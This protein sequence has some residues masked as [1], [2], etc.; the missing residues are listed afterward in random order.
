MLFNIIYSV[1]QFILRVFFR[2]FFSP[3]I[4]GREN[5][6]KTGGFIVSC[7]HKSNFDPALIGAYLPKKIS[8]LAKRELFSNKLFGWFLKGLGAI[9]ITRQIAEIGTLKK[10]IKLLK[11][12]GII[13]IF[14]EGTR[15]NKKNI[16]NVKSGAVLF[17]IKGQVPIQPAVIVGDYKLMGGLKLIFGKPIY[18][19]GYYNKKVSQEQLH[20]LSIDLMEHIYSLS[21][22]GNDCKNA[23]TT[24]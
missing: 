4:I 11:D 24:G 7:N 22:E 23:N 10:V 14:P 6:L 17:A 18:Y 5:I 8:F 20:N 9:P 12:G 13:T 1:A 3:H 21:D 19:T 16:N 2:I 15:S